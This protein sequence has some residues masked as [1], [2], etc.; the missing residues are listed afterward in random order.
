MI[1]VR[2][3]VGG[4][5]VSANR[6]ASELEKAAFT[7]VRDNITKALRDVRCSEHGARPT[8]VVKGTSLDNLKFEVHGCCENL[9]QRSLQKLQ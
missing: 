7:Q 9:I 2:F 3:E 6:F 4:R 8:V 1:D 5:K